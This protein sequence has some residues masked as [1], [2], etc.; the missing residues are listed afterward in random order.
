MILVF[1]SAIV[2]I[3][4]E[5]DH[6]P[7]AGETVLCP[8]VSLRPGG[9]GANQAVAAARAGADVVFVGAVGKDPLGD[10]LLDSL[11][12]ENIDLNDVLRADALTGVAA[13]A[14][15]KVG[16][17]QILVGGGANTTLRADQVPD[18][19][20]TPATTVVM[21]LE[22]PVPEI[23]ALAARAKANGAKV[24]L[25]LAPAQRVSPVLLETVD[26]L[27]MNEVEAGTLS[28]EA[29]Q[30]LALARNLSNR[31]HLVAVVTLGGDGAIAVA[32]E[33]I[34][35]VGALPVRVVDTVGAGD[36]FVGVM[37]AM[38]DRKAPLP[39][40]LH[41]ASVAAG[42]ACEAGGAQAA[43]PID[44]DVDGRLGDLPP[45]RLVT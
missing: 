18:R 26:V 23:T 14:V 27:I 38:L 21:Q 25:N 24:V 41:R 44:L 3:G 33:Q 40:A 22:V 4:F 43:L 13:V 28:G 31:H 8:D 19:H 36:A 39:T 1:G 34:W 12:A 6:L 45:P 29:G 10:L 20:L 5:A 9:K 2:D 35:S 16:E 42:M 37:A 7:R 15:D 11:A 30:P 32:K 17:N